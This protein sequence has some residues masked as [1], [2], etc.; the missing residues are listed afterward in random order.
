MKL[1][2]FIFFQ[3]AL[4]LLPDATHQATLSASIGSFSTTFPHSTNIE[5]NAAPR[6]KRIKQLTN[7]KNWHWASI[8]ALLFVGLCIGF[9][10]L[11]FAGP[12]T[13]VYWIIAICSPFISFIFAWI[14]FNAHKDIAE[15]YVENRT[16]WYVIMFVTC[17]IYI[18]MGILTIMLPILFFLSI[19][20]GYFYTG[21]GFLGLFRMW[22]NPPRIPP[23]PTKP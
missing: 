3:I 10:S 7:R 8:I 5:N 20:S 13:I 22:E 18:L 9:A 17:L 12:A 15:N 4:F 21:N 16:N 11:L 14:A 23:Y 1:I 19:M 6:P 2:L